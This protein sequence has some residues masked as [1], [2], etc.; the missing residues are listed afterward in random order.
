MDP[1]TG[2][3]V[4]V[5]IPDRA[6]KQYRL[7]NQRRYNEIVA[8][9]TQFAARHTLGG[10]A[11]LRCPE[12]LLQLNMHLD[13]NFDHLTYGDNGTRR[14]AGIAALH[15]DEL[16][17]FYAGLRSIARPNKLLYALVGLFV[18][19]QVVRATTVPPEKRHE[20]A[21]T[22]WA[23]ISDN[24]VVVRGK[25]GQSGRFDRCIPIG[26]WRDNA[27]RVCRHVEDA[28]GGLN[29]KDGYIQRSAVPPALLNA[30]K[31]YGWFLR[32]GVTLLQRN[33]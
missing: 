10:F 23:T 24:D 25:Q 1:I 13:P 27:Y 19:E 2:E 20:N 9:L 26:E 16:V 6:T 4:F 11:G 29:V 30:E 15:H 18:V 21:H 14:G 12:T 3:F 17:V 22:R 33:N 7:G 31:F 28:W 5:P 8:P 32:Q